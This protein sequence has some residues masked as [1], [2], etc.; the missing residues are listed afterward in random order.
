M[1]TYAL[2]PAAI[3]IAASAAAAP[4]SAA[5]TTLTFD[6]N[7]CGVAGNQVCTSGS[8]IG[9]NYGD[10]AQANVS[11][12]S[13]NTSTNATDE[14]FLKLW[15]SGYGD[16]NNVVWG[17]QNAAGYRSE[18]TL[19]PKA[20]FEIALLGFDAACYQNRASCRTLNYKVSSGSTV[21]DAASV[22]TNSPGHRSVALIGDYVRGPIVLS[23]GP[24]G[25]DVG[26]DNIA[27]DVRAVAGVPEPASW[28]M[29]L[30]GLGLMGA[31]ARRRTAS[32][33]ALA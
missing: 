26:L 22:S 29:M 25:Y 28:A 21:I 12:R 6:G 4:V 18:I 31:A 24:D 5:T 33:T 19:T 16:L 10:S 9:Q 8:Q 7:I 3:L 1:K 32:R 20:G 17:G 23:W 15:T 13:I 2:L 11:Y 14:A 27:F 30:G